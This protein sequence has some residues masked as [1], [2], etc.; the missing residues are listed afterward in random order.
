MKDYI[1]KLS[2]EEL[3]KYGRI[4]SGKILKGIFKSNPKE[5]QS[6]SYGK[7]PEAL[8]HEECIALVVRKRKNKFIQRV[9]NSNADY[10]VNETVRHIEENTDE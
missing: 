8:K 1:S 3:E 2:D 4:V 9:M 6:L 10:I 7:R 5:Y